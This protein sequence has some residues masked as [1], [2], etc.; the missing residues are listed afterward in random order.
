MIG[1]HFYQ[2]PDGHYSFD[3][4]PEIRAAEEANGVIGAIVDGIQTGLF[5]VAAHPERA[6]RYAGGWDAAQEALS[7][8]LI[9][10]AAAHSVALEQNERS[11]A[12]GLYRPEFWELLDRADPARE[13]SVVKGLDAHATDELKWM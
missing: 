4:P 7:R 2:H 8:R 11:K 3:D 12:Q 1:Q 10:A 6:F 13:V 9:H 5:A